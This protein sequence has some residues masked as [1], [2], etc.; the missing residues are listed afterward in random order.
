[1]AGFVNKVSGS[2][3]LAMAAHLPH[4]K[5]PNLDPLAEEIKSFQDKM[6]GKNTRIIMITDA[7]DLYDDWET[8]GILPK[9]GVPLIGTKTQSST[10]LFNSC[11]EPHFGITGYDQ[12]IA[13][14]GGMLRTQTDLLD[15]QAIAEWPGE[16]TN[17][18]LPVMGW[19]SSESVEPKDLVVSP[20]HGSTEN[21]H[22]FKDEARKLSEDRN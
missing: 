19:L 7:N 3:V 9:L 20:A 12:I 15:L 14:F 22:V 16:K 6:D 1:M 11:C 5:G 21:E 13:N 8:L 4:D 10:E 18:H 17:M 2:K